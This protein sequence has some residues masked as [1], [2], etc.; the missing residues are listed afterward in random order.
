MRANIFNVQA[1]LSCTLAAH[2]EVTQDLVSAR[3]L[4]AEDHR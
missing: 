1:A 4:Q 3:T 2:V